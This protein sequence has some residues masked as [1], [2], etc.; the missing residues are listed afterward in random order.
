MISIRNITNREQYDSFVSEG[1]KCLKIG[2]D[3]CG[4]CKVLE[5]IILNLDGTKLNDYEFGEINVDDEF[6]E[7]ITKELNIR[8]VPVTV[9]FKDGNPVDRFVGILSADEIYK[10]LV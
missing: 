6:A 2:A 7:D 4:P 3:W 5:N 9:I 1:N 10:K 8:N